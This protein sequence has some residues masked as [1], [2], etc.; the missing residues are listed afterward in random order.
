MRA[1]REFVGLVLA[2]LWKD[3]V[4]EVRSRDIVVSALV[5]ALLVIV[6]FNFAVSPTPQTVAFVAPG[7]L[8]VAFTFGGVLGLNRSMGLEKESGGMQALM[9]APVGRD[10]I[11]FG[12][13]LGNLLF[14]LL[15]ELA[16]FPVF[17]VLYNFSLLIPGL[18]PVALLTTL[19]IAAV[20]TL[21]SAIAVNT[22][23][24]EVMLPLLFLPV[25]APALIA[26][27]EASS[28]ALQGEAGLTRWLPFL[29]AYDA[30]F[31]VVCPFAFQMV[32]EE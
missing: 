25:I 8:W 20:G 28:A 14:M 6:V 12:K 9:L 26:A 3:V 18:L 2:I 13:M 23:S 24:R 22:R 15:I 16:A 30:L 27:V 11:F 31:L 17:A 5:F 7:I 32:A 19:G 21:F 29:A 10:V 1:L 4:L